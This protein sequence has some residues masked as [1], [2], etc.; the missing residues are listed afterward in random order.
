MKPLFLFL[1][2]SLNTEIVYVILKSITQFSYIVCDDQNFRITSKKR[3]QLELIDERNGDCTIIL[4]KIK[5]KNYEMW[6]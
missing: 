4:N 3:D 1:A 2:S 5:I 6:S